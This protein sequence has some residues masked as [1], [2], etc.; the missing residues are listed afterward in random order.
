M[1]SNSFR[2]WSQ[3]AI[4]AGNRQRLVTS[5]TDPI[6]WSGRK[7]RRVRCAAFL[8]AM[9]TDKL[10]NMSQLRMQQRPQVQVAHIENWKQI[11]PLYSCSH[12]FNMRWTSGTNKR[13][14]KELLEWFGPS[15]K[16]HS[17][18]LPACHYIKFYLFFIPWSATDNWFLCINLTLTLCSIHKHNL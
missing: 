18:T 11:G 3:A 17:I 5:H 10:I 7:E 9:I 1:T 6:W 4:S 2:G 8:P 14:A 15:I 12:A 13:V 16:S